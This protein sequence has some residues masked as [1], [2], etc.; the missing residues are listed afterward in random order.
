MEDRTLHFVLRHLR[1]SPVVYAELAFVADSAFSF[2]LQRCL[3]R[4]RLPSPH[5]LMPDHPVMLL[6]WITERPPCTSHVHIDSPASTWHPPD[7]FV[8]REPPDPGEPS[9]VMARYAHEQLLRLDE[10]RSGCDGRSAF[11]DDVHGLLTEEEQEKLR[12][13]DEG[14]YGEGSTA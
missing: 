9:S 1:H 2:S 7:D 8:D 11:F 5:D 6:F 13:W 14:E 10:V 12:R 4:L 3:P